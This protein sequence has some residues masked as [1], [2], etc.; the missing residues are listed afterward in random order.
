MATRNENGRLELTAAEESRLRSVGAL[1]GT[2]IETSSIEETREEH[3]QR[4][5][6]EHLQAVADAAG[7]DPGALR[8][9][10]AALDDDVAYSVEGEGENASVVVETG[11]EPVDFADFADEH[12]GPLEGAL[13]GADRPEEDDEAESDAPT[14]Q[15]G[16]GES[17]GPEA[18]SESDT[19]QDDWTA[20]RYR[21]ERQTDATW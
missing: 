4:E 18:E 12:F 20:D 3:R 2:T 7:V 13:Y 14:A 6:E 16:G 21:F 17:S 19:R 15:E 5:E 1:D 10:T 8:T 11:D 9:A